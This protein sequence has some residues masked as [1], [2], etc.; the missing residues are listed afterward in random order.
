VFI[1]YSRDDGGDFARQLK[2]RL[3]EKRYDVFLDTSSL[4][5]GAKWKPRIESAIDNSGIFVLIITPR[6]MESNEVKDEY[7]LAT[8]KKKLLMLFKHDSVNIDSLDWGLKDRNLLEFSTPESLIRKFDEKFR[9]IDELLKHDLADPFVVQSKLKGLKEEFDSIPPEY[10]VETVKSYADDN[11]IPIMTFLKKSTV[12]YQDEVKA[13]ER[14]LARVLRLS[15]NIDEKGENL[16]EIFVRTDADLLKSNLSEYLTYMLTFFIKNTPEKRLESAKHQSR[17]EIVQ[18]KQI[19]IETKDFLNISVDRSLTEND[20]Y[21]HFKQDIENQK[22][23]IKFFFLEPESIDLWF[24][25]INR[26]EYKFQQIGRDLIAKNVNELIDIIFEN[27]SPAS[28]HI[29]F[30]DLGVGAAVKD[31]YVIKAL[32]QKMPKDTEERMNYV[33]IDYSIGILQKTMDF[34]DELMDSY[35]NKLHIEGILGDFFQLVRYTDKINSISK[36]PKLFALLG[37]LFGNVDENK[38]LNRITKTM[39]SNDFLLLEI[40]LINDRTDDQLKEGYG[41]DEVTKSFLLNPVLNYFKAENKNTRARIEDFR[42]EVEIQGM[43]DIAKS[44]TVLTSACYGD[45]YDEKIELI[46]SNK[47]DLDALLNYMYD[48]WKLGHLKTYREQNACLL[49]LH[50]LLP[51]KVATESIAVVNPVTT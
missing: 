31:Y 47:Y 28:Q 13:I 33:P 34:L 17:E 27:C 18:V 45:N 49:L 38:I 40:D 12:F 16:E 22:I 19:A 23:D 44:K 48:R 25:I 14:I 46:H 1:S 4:S 37:N 10:S 51:Q 43:S 9:E 42:L 5:V 41:S 8:S 15:Q 39:N 30:I 35:P 24:R 2:K 29:D 7:S 50:K 21:E 3:E 32:L 20:K 11:F 26:S 6:T 36:S